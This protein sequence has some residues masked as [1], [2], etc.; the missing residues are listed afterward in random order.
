MFPDEAA[1]KAYL[2][3]RRWPNGIACPRCGNETVFPVG[4]LPFKWQCYNR[5][6]DKKS[7]SRGGQGSGKTP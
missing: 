7:S 6:W 1:C 2:R 5:H 3:A 4:S